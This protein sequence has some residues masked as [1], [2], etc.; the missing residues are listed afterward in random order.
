MYGLPFFTTAGRLSR[1]DEAATLIREL[2]DQPFSDFQG[3][4]YRLRKAT[5]EPKPIQK[6]LPLLIGG[7]GERK[8]LRTVA[9]SADLWHTN[10]GPEVMAHKLEVL[11]RHCADVQRDPA[12]IL[13]LA[14]ER[15]F[16]CVRSS[17]AEVHAWAREVAR[18]SRMSTP[19]ELTHMTV[20]GLVERLLEYWKVG[21][22]GFIFYTQ[23]PFD[24]ETIER[25]AREVRPRFMQAI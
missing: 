16:V 17:E 13:P 14:T 20:D 22:R 18:T 2:L 11:R 6:R 3:K 1:M 21:V 23:A 4:H 12:E 15:P 8:T 9:K 24:R 5:C 7:A 10:A 25:I 19:P